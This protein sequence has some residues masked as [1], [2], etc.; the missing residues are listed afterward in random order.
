MKTQTKHSWNMD[1]R[2]DFFFIPSLIKVCGIVRNAAPT[3]GI[4][5][6]KINQSFAF[7][8]YYL[9]NRHRKPLMKDPL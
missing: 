1:W 5:E 9:K 6:Q 8:L 3:R 2:F 7:H 4:L